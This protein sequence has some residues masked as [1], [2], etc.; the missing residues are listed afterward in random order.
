MFNAAAAFRYGIAQRIVDDF[1]EDPHQ[2]IGLLDDWIKFGREQTG[3]LADAESKSQAKRRS[4][5]WISKGFPEGVSF[6]CSI[7]MQTKCSMAKAPCSKL[8]ALGIELWASGIEPFF[9]LRFTPS[10]ERYLASNGSCGPL[11]AFPYLRSFARSASDNSA[12]VDVATW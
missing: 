5:S 1:A 7:Q 8:N 2:F 12:P 9:Y 11:Y 4:L 3:P 10:E 6:V